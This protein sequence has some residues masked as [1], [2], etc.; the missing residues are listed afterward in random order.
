MV[1]KII[2]KLSKLFIKNSLPLS[3]II[4]L[5][6]VIG[7]IVFFGINYPTKEVIKE[8]KVE[9]EVIK[10]IE[11]KK[12]K[13]SEFVTY[14]NPR[15]DP[16]IAEEIGKAVDKYSKEYKIPSKLILS[17]IKKESFFNPFAKSHV[18]FGLMQIY[19][20]FHKDKIEKLGIKDERQI[21]HIDN[22][23]NLGCQILSE[24]LEKEKYDLHKALHS[25]LSKK[26]SEKSKNAYINDIL[27]TWAMLNF[28]E[29]KKETE[30]KNK[31]DSME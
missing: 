16:I 23:I 21:Y 25:Y 5:L 12:I 22:N 27:S 20:K 15:I 18:A 9:K 31:N 7:F 26:A 24:Y 11:P 8:I 30:R 6:S 3:I 17:I 14:I 10:Y 29:F 2:R 1:S 4:G 28:L 19:P 13:N